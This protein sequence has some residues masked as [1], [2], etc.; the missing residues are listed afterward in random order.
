MGYKNRTFSKNKRKN[1]YTRLHGGADAAADALLDDAAA[2][3]YY[4]ANIRRWA[5][6]RKAADA[7]AAE[8]RWEKANGISHVNTADFRRWAAAAVEAV[9]ADKARAAAREEALQSSGGTRKYRRKPRRKLKSRR[10]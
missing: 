8:R 9:E 10:K 5:A 6:N 2:D 4:A 7:K 3:A 1:H